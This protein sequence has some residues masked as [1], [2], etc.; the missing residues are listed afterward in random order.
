MKDAF[1]EFPEIKTAFYSSCEA[2]S[3]LYTRLFFIRARFYRR[4]EPYI[5]KK[6]ML[7]KIW[8]YGGEGFD[9][10][11]SLFCLCSYLDQRS[12]IVLYLAFLLCHYLGH[13]GHHQILSKL[14]PK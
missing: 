10:M 9:G 11:I 1:L 4:L 13:L 3:M 5:K 8:R 6:W 12:S 7:D 2:E 14:S